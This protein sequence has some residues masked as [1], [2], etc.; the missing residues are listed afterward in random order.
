MRKAAIA[1]VSVLALLVGACGNG[2]G[3]RAGGGDLEGTTI[4]FSVSLAEEEQAAIRDL[5]DDFESD[6]GATVNLTSVS[7]ADLPQKLRVEVGAGNPTVHLFAQDNL[8]L[9]VLVDEDLVE[10][11]SDV[12]LPDGIIESMIPEQF[13]GNTYFLPFRPNVRI[14]YANRERLQAAGVERPTTHTEFRAVAEALAEEGG[15]PKVTLSLAEGD[16]GA[17]TISEW[18]VSFGGN[19]LIL[20]DEG[21]AQAFAFL[22]G[23]WRDNLLARESL[24]AKFDTEVDYLQGETSW[25]AQNWPV[26]SAQLDEQGLLDRFIVYE[27]WAG[28]E[29]AA[30]VIGGDVLG[31]PRGVSEQEKE[32]ALALA[33][34]LISEDA[35]KT[36]VERNAWPSVR[37]DAYSD[38]SD[39]QED[40]FAAI[41]AALEDGWYR[42]NVAYWSNVSEQLNTAVRRIIV[43][44][45][46]VQA[47]L[48]QLH[49][50][51]RAAA[52]Q[53]GAEYPP[54]DGDGG[55]T[56]SP[57]AG[58]TGTATPSP[59]PEETPQGD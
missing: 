29:R 49:T 9:K 3:G 27:G 22:Q 39:E 47:T 57:A 7:S 37:D 28:P 34:F 16:P 24:L 43:D 23:M 42:P 21:S 38:V 53:A 51:I 17:V 36:L 58:A 5:L 2:D 56:G 59:S 44:G 20:N 45:E 25:L 35:Q 52:E 48:D 12:E 41:Q 13:D 8:A 14:A 30:H 11:L 50:N 26:T 55:G 46:P 54:A 18:I 32:A 33:D 40:T 1:A 4:T 6:T 15:T 19:P 31:I 10:D